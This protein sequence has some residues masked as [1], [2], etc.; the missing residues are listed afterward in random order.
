M[1]LKAVLWLITAW[2][3]MSR[4]SSAFVVFLL[5]WTRKVSVLLNS[6]SPWRLCLNLTSKRSMTSSTGEQES[7]PTTK[8]G[9]YS[10]GYHF[11]KLPAD[12][13]RLIISWRLALMWKCFQTR[14]PF[15]LNSHKVTF[16]FTMV[17]WLPA[18]SF[19]WGVFAVIL[20]SSRPGVTL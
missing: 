3:M 20:A 14:E 5:T 10:D 1:I 7:G 4:P 9:N 18:S 16:C 15:V 2:Q 6:F 17:F 13:V 11:H 12:D 8:V 19:F